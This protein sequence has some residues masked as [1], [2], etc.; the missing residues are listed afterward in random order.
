MKVRVHFVLKHLESSTLHMSPTYDGIFYT[1]HIDEKWFYMTRASQN[2]YMLPCEPLPHRTCKS[3][4]FITKIMFMSTIGRPRYDENGVC[5]FDCKIGIF[6]FTIMKPTKQESKNKSR[7]VMEVK[8]IE[9]ITKLV[10]K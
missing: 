3:K 10:I 7:G 2:F 1:I 6:P 4:K 9:S 5:T 8:T